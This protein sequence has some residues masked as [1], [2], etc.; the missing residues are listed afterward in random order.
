[1]LELSLNEIERW[2]AAVFWP[3][4]RISAFFMV[5]PIIGTRLVP[6]QIRILLAGAY[7]IMIF[8]MIPPIPSID[9][10]SA[11]SFYIVIQQLLIGL[12]LGFV[13]QILFQIAV[14]GGQIV[15]MQ[16]GLGFAMMV[17]PINGVSVASVSQLYLMVSNLIFLSMNGHIVLMQVLAQSFVQ[18]PLNSE[19]KTDSLMQVAN[20]GGWMFAAGLLVALPA[21]TALLLVNISFGLMARVAPQLNI[22]TVGFPFN[23]ILGLVVLWVSLSAYLPQFTQFTEESLLMMQSLL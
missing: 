14:L 21:V 8:P 9:L 5:V 23:M 19:F 6:P 2:L 20:M 13:V 4:F 17:D 3:F 22:F 16:N 10:V 18:L 11:Q 15:A 12:V 1:M 7:T